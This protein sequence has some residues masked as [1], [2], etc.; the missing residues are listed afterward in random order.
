MSAGDV[1][2][3]RE[4]SSKTRTSPRPYLAVGPEVF[5]HYLPLGLLIPKVPEESFLIRII[6]IAPYSL[7]RIFMHHRNT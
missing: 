4:T 7:Q 1:A 6:L 2:Y 5:Y 3:L